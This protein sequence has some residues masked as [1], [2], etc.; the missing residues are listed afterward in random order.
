M[1][2][3]LPLRPAAAGG[4]AGEPAAP[5]EAGEAGDDQTLDP[6]WARQYERIWELVEQQRKV[7]EPHATACTQKLDIERTEPDDVG[8]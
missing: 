7:E 3:V 2:V 6:N 8:G 1:T 4:R 5:G